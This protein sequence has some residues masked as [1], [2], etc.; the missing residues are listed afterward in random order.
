MEQLLNKGTQEEIDAYYAQ[1]KEILIAPTFE[2]MIAQS[3][4]LANKWVAEHSGKHDTTLLLEQNST[5][6]Y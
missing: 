5:D 2:E 4:A 6:G 3:A 1:M